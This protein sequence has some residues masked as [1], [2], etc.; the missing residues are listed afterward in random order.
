MRT[1]DLIR[2]MVE[3]M[4]TPAPG[5][6]R[7]LGLALTL[8]FA[9]SAAAFAATLGPRDDIAAALSTVRFDLKLLQATLLAAATAFL[10]LRLVRPAASTNAGKMW[11]AAAAGLVLL[12]VAAELAVLAPSQWAA[13]AVGNNAAVCLTAIPALALP[14][15]IAVLLA[16]R[17]GAPTRPA[18]AGAVAGLLAGSLS[19]LLYAIH[20]TDDS[21][22][23]VALWY[24]MA[25]AIVTLA[26]AAAGRL[27]LRW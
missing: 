16:L 1:D 25:L 15:M 7:R 18:L 11:L 13:A 12:A 10:A 20:C 14:I 9:V 5:L 2:T 27:F 8:G 24:G 21:P 17:A 22:L 19:A 3:D 6:M 4:H 26:G 23:F